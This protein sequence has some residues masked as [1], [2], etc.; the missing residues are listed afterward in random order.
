MRPTRQLWA[1]GALAVSLAAFALLVARPAALLGTLAI[2]TWLV[3]RQSQFLRALSE[4]VDALTVEQTA[5]TTTVRAGETTPVTLTARASTPVP[6]A[7]AVDAGIPL[8]G[9]L[10]EALSVTLPP[11]GTRVEHTA[12]VT[13]PIAGEHRFDRATL[14]VSDGR[15]RQSLPVGSTP[16][17]RV[18]PREP[19]EVHVGV[20][21][22]RVPAAP[23]DHRGGLLGSS[24]E[25]TE[26]REYQPGD[27]T[28]R[29]DWKTTARLAS[30][31]V[32]EFEGEMDR[33]V[34]LVVD[35]RRSLR[36]GPPAETKLDYLRETALE[37]ADGARQAGDPLGLVT[38]DDDGVHTRLE[39][40]AGTT[41]YGRVRRGLF[42]LSTDTGEADHRRLRPLAGAWDERPG[43][44]RAD[45]DDE[46]A[47]FV[48]S[49]RPFLDARYHARELATAR[50]FL[51]GLSE[52]LAN[53]ERQVV[54]VLCTD[55]ERPQELRDAITTIREHG[56]T[57]LVLLAP[58]ALFEP[59]GLADL[60][61]A[62]DRYV[63]F[64]RLRRRLD[65]L[66]GVRALEVA[67][68]GRV[69]SV[70]AGREAP[71]GRP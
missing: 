38:L 37:L 9:R 28:R 48:R 23:G 59:D 58:T 62:Y 35:T 71:E 41:S 66:D 7:V 40:A 54:V 65:G 5:V 25:P 6:A 34:L 51:G 13:W 18:E 69:A 17:V 53:R 12:S 2:G 47:A 1:I 30:P 19:R 42:D 10:T 60:E 33:P 11:G 21:G 63:A 15:V 31:H 44:L 16:S 52:S 64:E 20:R 46:A 32:R 45:A 61:A 68:D 29:I 50:S 24:L 36:T 27:A 22:Q 3:V 39:P 43:A 56:H 67:P 57:V 8:A 14:T 49:L 55:D 26:I 70:L 4:T